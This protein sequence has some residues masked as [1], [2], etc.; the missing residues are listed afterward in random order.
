MFRAIS[1][2]I[3]KDCLNQASYKFSFFT[4]LFSAVA[5]LAVYYFIDKLF[6]YKITGYLEEFGV[7]YFSYVLLG[8]SFFSYTGVGISSFSGCIRQEQLQGTLEAVFLSPT[9]P[10][11]I[12]LSMALWNFI[13]ATVDTLIYIGLGIF[14][15]KV[16]FSAI[17][18]SSS[19]VIL[20]LAIL[21][22][23]SLGILSAS[24]VLILKKGDPA[25]WI[26]NSFEGLL[27]GVYF[28][29]EVMPPFLQ[30]LAKFIP[31]TYAV[32]G[33]QFAVY[34]GY[35]LAELKTE[36]GF[37][38]LFSLLLTP[39]SIFSFNYALRIARRQ[40]GLAQY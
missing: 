14:L 9:K 26:M 12:L 22:F 34:K 13:F 16:D 4:T 27:G 37:L 5:S 20:I 11:I 17:N 32:R 15:F 28:P 29:V 33:I 18:F 6:G 19:V 36:C 10:I 24:F 2:I 1:A 21:S 31:I 38:L 3:K 35:S 25:G 8:V 30:F 39:F 7:N 23:S 40:G